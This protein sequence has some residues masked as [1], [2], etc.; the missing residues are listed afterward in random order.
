VPLLSLP[1]NEMAPE[2]LP[3][4]YAVNVPAAALYAQVY[5]DAVLTGS[6]VV[7]LFTAFPAA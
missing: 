7:T 2:A 5:C 3:F 4:T 6:T 1:D